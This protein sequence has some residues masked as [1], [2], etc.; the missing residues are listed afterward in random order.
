MNTSVASTISS[1]VM[2]VLK[3]ACCVSLLMILAG[4]LIVGL[5]NEAKSA[6]GVTTDIIAGEMIDL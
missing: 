1:S 2:E 3:Q 6:I 4:K 5:S